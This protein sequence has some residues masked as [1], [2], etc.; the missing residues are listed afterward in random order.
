MSEKATFPGRLTRVKAEKV[1][2]PEE[3]ARARKGALASSGD[4][5]VVAQVI[6]LVEEGARYGRSY[7]GVI[8][9]VA[10]MLS[11]LEQLAVAEKL[12]AMARQALAEEA[13]V[14][15]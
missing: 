6:D 5:A 9:G 8:L 2:D 4:P 13:R 15:V 7:A 3:L 1:T 11:P 10:E 12:L 14:A